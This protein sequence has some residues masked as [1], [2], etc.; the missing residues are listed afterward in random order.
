MSK[1]KYV[2]VLCV[3]LTLSSVFAFVTHHHSNRAE[4][5]KCSVCAAGHSA[6][7]RPTASSLK[8]TFTP[9]S[10]FRTAPDS[11]THRVVAFALSVRPP[12]AI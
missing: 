9:I 12:P 10:V 11:I 4:S 2:V 8:A 5:I 1:A 6:A 3:L 7:A